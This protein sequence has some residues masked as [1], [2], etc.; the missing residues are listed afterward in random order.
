MHFWKEI[1]ERQ[2]YYLFINY[3]IRKLIY[4]L[5]FLIMSSLI[6]DFHKFGSLK[7]VYGKSFEF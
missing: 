4:K 7:R 2:K 3:H 6:I 5:I 1:G